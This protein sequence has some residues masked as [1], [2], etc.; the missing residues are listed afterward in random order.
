MAQ[1]AMVAD[2]L[3][4]LARDREVTIVEIHS[5]GDQR[6]DS[7]LSSLGI[8]TFTSTLERALLDDRVDLAIHS[9]K[10]LPTESAPGLV[11]VPVLE[12][13]DPRDVLLN[14]W[15]QTLLDL[16]DGARIGTSSPRREAQLRHG[17]PEL[18]YRPIRGNVETR[19]AKATGDDYDGVVLAAAGIERLGLSDHVS[20]YI[21]TRVIAPAPGQGAIAAQ[22]RS[23]DDA[24]LTLVRALRHAPTAAAVEAER[25][26][27]RA[28]G[29]GCM[30][31]IGAL[32]EV[33]GDSLTLFATVTAL[34]GSQSYRVEV[35][36]PVEDPDVAGRAAYAA[37]LE[38]GA[39]AIT[40][41]SANA[42]TGARS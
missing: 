41:P 2:A 33:D 19:I 38:Q 13:A 25:W 40:G 20:E 35:A 21:S 32:A 18:D 7:P 29:A 39:G 5:E 22:T 8:G 10:D 30:V 12:R 42:E 4:P 24:T 6:P 27:L 37:L 28:A 3:R 15:S 36:G 31:P 16:P 23:D 11:V 9:L 26:V 34:D 14:R 17:R 1:T